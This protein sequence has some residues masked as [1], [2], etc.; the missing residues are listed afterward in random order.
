[1]SGGFISV[2]EDVFDGAWQGSAPV[3]SGKFFLSA[4]VA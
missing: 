1:M 3:W 4:R 2:V